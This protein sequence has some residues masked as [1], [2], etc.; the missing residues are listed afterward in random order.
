[1]PIPEEA[2][3]VAVPNI[4]LHPGDLIEVA[5]GPDRLNRTVRL[6]LTAAAGGRIAV[7]E[8]ERVPPDAMRIL[9]I[10]VSDELRAILRPSAGPSGAIRPSALPELGSS[11]PEAGSPGAGG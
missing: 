11:D 9:S 10:L 8:C 3:P 1:M 4:V 2:P 5:P 7:V 6:V